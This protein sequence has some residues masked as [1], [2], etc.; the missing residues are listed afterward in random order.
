MSNG[1]TEAFVEVLALSG[2]HLAHTEWE[3]DAI[4]WLAAHD[5]AVMGLGMVGFDVADLSWTADHLANEK[6]FLFRVIDGASMRYAWDR[7]SYE[8]YIEWLFPRLEAFRRLIDALTVEEVRPR[9][10][11]DDWGLLRHDRA[12]CPRH[13]VYLHAAGCIVCNHGHLSPVAVA[14]AG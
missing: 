13:E 7:L 2:S 8:P 5:Q 12:R 3:I 6:A 10:G 4:V 11:R 9:S 14:S 1:L